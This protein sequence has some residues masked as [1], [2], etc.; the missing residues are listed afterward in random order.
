MTF[1]E[2]FYDLK[3]IYQKWGIQSTENTLFSLILI[4][5]NKA[6]TLGANILTN[7]VDIGTG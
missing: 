5:I 4:V 2:S 6:P 7:S 1:E 3:N